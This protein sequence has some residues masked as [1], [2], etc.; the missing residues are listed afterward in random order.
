ME[1]T[2]LNRAVQ[3]YDR[4]LQAR[5]SGAVGRFC[6]ERHHGYAGI[7]TDEVLK[8]LHDR[9]IRLEAESTLHPDNL[10]L[11]QDKR[12]A[13]DEYESRKQGFQPIFYVHPS[14]QDR[15]NDIIC[16]LIGMDIRAAGGPAAWAEK[17]KEGQVAA[18]KA[19]RA[20][21]RERLRNLAEESYDRVAV[22]KDFHGSGGDA[23]F[24]AH[25]KK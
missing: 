19:I 10:D 22:K 21:R 5:W 24:Y 15:T 23:Y 7:G 8:M 4:G 9:W 16:I 14:E 11:E 2:G 20:K 13:Y 3:E 18:T 1:A 6:V 12:F 17:H 25:D